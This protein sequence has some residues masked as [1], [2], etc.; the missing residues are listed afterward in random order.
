MRPGTRVVSRRLTSCGLGL[1]LAFVTGFALWAAVAAGE[2]ADA[3]GRASA[4]SDAYGQARYAAGAEESLERKYRL[5]PGRDV[6][7]SF[8]AAAA[9]LASALRI[10]GRDGVKADRAL[11]GDLLV[12]HRRYLEAISQ[13]FRAVDAGDAKRVLAIDSREVD[14]VFHELEEKVAAA[15][16][17]H[18]DESLTSLRSLARTKG[19]LF[20]GIPVSFTLG[21]LLIALFLV[22]LLRH[23]RQAE[24]DVHTAEARYRTLVEQLPLAT[25]IEL[26]DESSATYMSP[27]IKS[28]V[29][30]SAEE[31]TADRAFFG[32]VLHPDDREHV[33]GGFRE[34]H[35]A[36]A[37][38]ECEYRLIASDASVV[39][40][41][42]AAV[43]GRDEA[44]RPLY[45][46]GYMV[47]IT[48]RKRAE[49]ALRESER[50]FRDLVSGI[51]AIVWEAD[52]DPDL[53]F[54]FVSKRAEE[55]LGYPVERWLA[56][57][58]FAANFFHP[59]DRERV[60]E[61]DKQAIKNGEDFELEY[62]M[63]AADGRTVWFH[64]IVRVEAHDDGRARKLR[65]IMVDV[66]AQRS[67][68]S[69][70]NRL[71]EQL[72][73]SQ[74][75]EAIGRLAG[76]IAHDFNNLLTV[77]SSYSVLALNR[78]DG[79][80]PSL[81][82]DI[83]E[84]KKS[85]ERAAALT[86]Q[87]LAFSRKQILQPKRLDLNAV[88][89]E[90]EKLLRR[91]IGEDIELVCVF[92]E[93]LGRVEVDPGQLEQVILNLAV[94]ARDAMPKGGKLA[95]ETMNVEL[96]ESYARDY[97]DVRPGSYV[98]LAVSDNG[99]G[100]D[101]E[102]KAHAFEPFFTTKEVG[103]GTGLGLATVYGIIEQ[104]GG[105]ISVTSEPGEGATFKVYL[106]MVTDA[107]LEEGATRQRSLG[108]PR[109]AETILLVEDEQ[110]VRELASRILLESGYTILEAASP[111]EAQ[112]IFKQ[113]AAPIHLLLSDVVMPQMRG[114]ELAESL[115]AL[116]PELCILYMSGY[117]DQAIAQHELLDAE[118]AFL[119]KPFTPTG[120]LKKVRKLLDSRDV[121]GPAGAARGSPREV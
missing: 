21:G 107:P 40:I 58:G 84:V 114:P 27:Q 116:R 49:A 11:T 34:M 87:L 43:I 88:V 118:T 50:R 28:L 70:R 95:I 68:E 81:R 4:V 109:G 105:H 6:R 69:E 65:G 33:L 72:R 113:Y 41:H 98:V 121:R 46:Q 104:S 20:I 17:A 99:C 93:G 73:Q 2:S 53:R 108:G 22:L 42:D 67:A 10:A 45:A 97:A 54:T 35:Q 115:R 29:G 56:E 90:A 76:G 110:V 60:I 47:D 100:M 52:P 79:R 1:V 39:W 57:P 80:D 111:G 78:L 103:K 75:I 15:A 12:L 51:D 16:S 66:T 85:A 48:E 30:Y 86:R 117:T 82:R 55:L 64:E 102:T 61:Q 8:D 25:Y 13:M 106:P 5:E 101:A 14:P 96:D 62:R 32:K 59:D 38:F 3:V 74:K 71:E 92:G 119:Q 23:K 83:E 63:L 36:G 44:G 18:R 112:R 94:N 31:W 24:E 77:I 7:A 91:L 89:A 9:S 19:Y 120:L 26:L 37:H